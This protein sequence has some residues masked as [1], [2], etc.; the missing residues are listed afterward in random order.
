MQRLRITFSR[1][2]EL[3]Y[4]THLDLM[5][6]WQRALRRAE[7]PL[8]Y[9][10]GFSPHPQLSLATPL[11][12]GVTGSGE[13]MDIHLERRISPHFFLKT[14]TPQLP[15]GITV[16]EIVETAPKTPSLQSLMRSAEYSIVIECARDKNEIEDAIAFLLQKDDLPWQH[17]RDKE[18]RKY[19]LR[20]LIDDLWLIEWQPAVCV[21][22]MLLRCDSTG[23]GRPEQ[24]ALALG[25][26]ETP[27]SL[28]RNRLLLAKPEKSLPRR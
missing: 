14:I 23:T 3:K 17:A 7:V 24:V 1:G 2:E 8:S 25:F 4:I 22:G 28:H 9:S 26:T 18:I 5:R 10:Q 6:L 19:D 11:A 12:V 13:L 21:I 20:R 16:S 27:K 15:Q